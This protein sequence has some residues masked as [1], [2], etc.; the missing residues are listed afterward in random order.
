MASVV[1]DLALSVLWFTVPAIAQIRSLALELPPALGE[2]K[3]KKKKKKTLNTSH[4]IITCLAL[5]QSPW[6]GIVTLK[7]FFIFPERDTRAIGNRRLSKKEFV[8]DVNTFFFLFDGY[9]K[10]S[11]Y[12]LNLHFCFEGWYPFMIFLAFWICLLRPAHS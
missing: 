4:Y 2:A 5:G 11:Y 6:K 8:V 7:G 1:K 10:I 3:K 9:L 12:H